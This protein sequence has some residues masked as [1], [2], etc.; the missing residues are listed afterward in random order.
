MV[1]GKK[2]PYTAK[3]KKMAKMEEAMMPPLSSEVVQEEEGIKMAEV[4]EEELPKLD[5]APIEDPN[6]I[7]R[8]ETNRKNYGKKLQDPQSSFL[9]KLY[10]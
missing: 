2:F 1:N 7:L 3:G 5:G 9:S 8:F 4:D 6:A 10:N